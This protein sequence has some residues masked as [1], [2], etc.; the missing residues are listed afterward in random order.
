MHRDQVGV[1]IV[2][3]MMML[4]A[5][6]LVFVLGSGGPATFVVRRF[7]FFP[8]THVR[9][10]AMMVVDLVPEHIRVLVGL[11]RFL[12]ALRNAAAPIQKVV[13]AIRTTLTVVLRI[14]TVT[15]LEFEFK[16]LLHGAN[17]FDALRRREDSKILNV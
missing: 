4:D 13:N 17:H 8:I 10:H 5:P 6:E 7:R 16:R 15:P 3:L 14:G 9:E 1:G 12:D 11:R 2:V